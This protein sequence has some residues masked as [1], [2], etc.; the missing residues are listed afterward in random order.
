MRLV[1]PFLLAASLYACNA[2]NAGVDAIENDGP[3]PS[4]PTGDVCVDAKAT[5]TEHCTLCHR[6]DRQP[7]PLTEESLQSSLAMDSVGR[8]GTPI[9]TPG[10]PDQS[11]LL[12]RVEQNQ[13]PPGAPLSDEQKLVLRSWISDGAPLDCAASEVMPTSH[14]P[15]GWAEPQNHGRGLKEASLNCRECH[16]ADF[17]GGIGPS[18]DSCHQPDWRT[19]CTYCHGGTQ[20]DTGAP[21]RSLFDDEDPSFGAHSPH[22]SARNHAPFACSQC[23]LEPEAVTSPGHVLDGTAG[24]AEVDFTGGLSPEASVVGPGSCD[25]LYCHGDGRRTGAWEVMLGRPDCGDC[26]PAP[27]IRDGWGGMSGAHER[28]L[29]ED[30]DCAECHAQ[31][32]DAM[33]VIIGLDLHVNGRPDVTTPELSRAGDTCDGTCHMEPHDQRTWTE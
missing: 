12:Q 11:V 7:P 18:C 4:T 2:T 8:P 19:T 14:H 29:D 9:V 25:N 20:N 24:R 33:N 10:A 27:L 21:P 3:P 31:T 26:H 16:G 5:L 17:T 6:A 28:H 15:E 32:V 22:V 13:M 1:V 23:H 30:I